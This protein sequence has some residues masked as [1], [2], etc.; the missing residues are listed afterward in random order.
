MYDQNVGIIR[1]NITIFH[2]TYSLYIVLSARK[3]LGIHKHIIII[4]PI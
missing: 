4:F 2:C 3:H 1:D